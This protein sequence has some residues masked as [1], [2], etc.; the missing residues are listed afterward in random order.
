MSH[1]A[2]PRRPV[3]LSFRSAARLVVLAFT[4]A[5][6]R[7]AWA[8]MGG[9][10]Q[11]E[12]DLAG[13]QTLTQG[14]G[15]RAFG[16]GGA[17]LARADDATAASWN[18]AGLSYLRL[19]EFSLVGNYNA[20]DATQGNDSDRLRSGVL[21]FAS[22]TWPVRIK[23]ASGSVQVN[24]QRAVSFDGS[25]MIERD[26]PRGARVF[27]GDQ[28]GGFDLIAFG[29]GLKLT[30]T[31]RLGATLNRWFD[32]YSVTLDKF[33]PGLV[34]ERR[35]LTIDFG[36]SGWNS[37]LGA[38]WSP[39]DE[40]NVAAVFKTA[41]TAK[42]D[43]RRSRRDFFFNSSGEVIAITENEFR[44]REV[45]LDFPWALGFGVSW[46]PRSTLT[47]SADYTRTNWSEARIRNYFTLRPTPP[48]AQ[49]PKPP[50]PQDFDDPLPYP[51]VYLDAQNDTEEIRAGIEY[52]LLRGRLKIPIRA[53]YFNDR[54]INTSDVLE[55]PPRFNG[56]TL[57]TGI[58]VGPVLFDLGYLYEWGESFESGEIIPTEAAAVARPAVRNTVR[59]QRFF[60]S[61]IYRFG[62]RP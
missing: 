20:F 4:L 29:T 59:N 52:V 45:R 41:F 44:R 36:I 13:R 62:G 11:D 15:A 40:L 30:R 50:E 17:F 46:R 32:G 31:L 21:D 33:T 24:Y 9:L 26:D 25:R 3:A 51:Y 19:S 18:P 48:F 23:G 56:F 38:I 47:L 42:V 37:N 55:N 5:D 43:L 28:S 61:F 2:E 53:G 12:I 58:I 16:M 60:A 57:G 7:L 10:E 39:I 54:P 8:Q 27:N 22:L 49:P 34:R 14:A 1:C 6:A 35:I